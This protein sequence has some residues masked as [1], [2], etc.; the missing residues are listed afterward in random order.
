MTPE[1]ASLV[2]PTLHYVLDLANRLKNS[3]QVDMKLERYRIR[4]ELQR[5]QENASRVAGKVRPADFELARQVLVCWTDEVLTNAY[6]AWQ[7]ATLEWEYFNTQDRAWNFYVVGETKARNASGDVIELWYLALVLGFEGD[8]EDGF[9]KMNRN[10][11]PPAGVDDKVARQLWAKELERQ[12]PRRQSLGE[13]AKP[14]LTCNVLP[15]RG[16]A[17]F[18][19]TLQWAGA[20][21]LLFCILVVFKLRS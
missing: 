1:F 15:L 17:F 2:N 11:F 12:I 20:L 10:D 4:E 18:V 3:E 7:E 14:A 6:P 13:L 8:I 5:A 19:T 9:A 16:A 21:F